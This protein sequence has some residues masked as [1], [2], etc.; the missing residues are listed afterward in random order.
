MVAAGCWERLKGC[1]VLAVEMMGC[2]AVLLL[3][4]EAREGMDEL[5]VEKRELR[6]CVWWVR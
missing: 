3:V 5:L 4:H 1:V 2:W 6:L